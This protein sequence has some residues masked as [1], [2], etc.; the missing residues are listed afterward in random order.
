MEITATNVVLDCE[1]WIV[2][3]APQI[4]DVCSVDCSL[5]F[6]DRKQQDTRSLN[7]VRTSGAVLSVELSGIISTVRRQ[8]RRNSASGNELL[9]QAFGLCGPALK[10]FLESLLL[11]A[12]G[13]AHALALPDGTVGW[14]R[15]TDLLFHKQ[16]L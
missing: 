4:I 7:N 9:I 14:V 12:R 3:S 8:A 6:C 13:R 5:R 1:H 16:A 15:T 11:S 10:S 2:T